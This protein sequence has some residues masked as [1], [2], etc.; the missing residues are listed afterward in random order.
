LAVFGAPTM[1][2]SKFGIG[3][4]TASMRRAMA[5]VT[6]WIALACMPSSRRPFGQFALGLMHADLRKLRARRLDE[7]THKSR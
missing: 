5:R 7:S 6:S 2:A 3:M 4:S 1:T